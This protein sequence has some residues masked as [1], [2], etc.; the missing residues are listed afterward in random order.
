[1][2]ALI[3]T[4]LVYSTGGQIL[5]AS[6]ASVVGYQS[7]A[8]CEEVARTLDFTEANAKRLASCIAIY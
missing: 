6:T 5:S 8:S 4:I 7:K 3:I 2:Y 1:M